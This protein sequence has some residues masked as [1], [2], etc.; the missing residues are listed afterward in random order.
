[1]AISALSVLQF[2]ML[3]CRA[4]FS[5]AIMLSL[6]R[7]YRGADGSMKIPFDE[8]IFEKLIER[9]PAREILATFK[10]ILRT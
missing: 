1:M 5:P 10:D 2:E 3:F 4:R 7:N 8:H 6:L 9:K